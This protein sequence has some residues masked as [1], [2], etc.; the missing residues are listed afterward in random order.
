MP[1]F[2]VKFI[3]ASF[4]HKSKP[5]PHSSLASEVKEPRKQNKT[6]QKNRFCTFLPPTLYPVKKPISVCFTSYFLFSVGQLQKREMISRTYRWRPWNVEMLINFL[7]WADKRRR[8]CYWG[9]GWRKARLLFLSF[10]SLTLRMRV[11]S[12]KEWE[13][14]SAVPW[15]SA[16]WQGSN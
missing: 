13:K 3:T 6:K 8:K 11:K 5:A 7:Q 14:G 2:P 12:L 15:P 16:Q 9:F 10:V 1:A 4:S